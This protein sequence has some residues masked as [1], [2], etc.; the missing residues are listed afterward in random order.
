M[1]TRNGND[2]TVPDRIRDRFQREMG[3]D[4]MKSDAELTAMSDEDYDKNK[5]RE[6]RRNVTV[7]DFVQSLVTNRPAAEQGTDQQREQRARV[8]A[9]RKAMPQETRRK[10]PNGVDAGDMDP[11]ITF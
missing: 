3:A 10:N 8:E 7:R 1:A 9:Q 5:T 6:N 4:T 11:K 2:G